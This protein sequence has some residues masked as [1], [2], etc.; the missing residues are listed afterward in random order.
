MLERAMRQSKGHR[1]LKQCAK[2]VEI[3]I[4]VQPG[5]KSSELVGEYGGALKIKLRAQPVD[6]KANAALVEFMSSCLGIPKSR[7]HILSGVTVRRKKILVEGLSLDVVRA[8]LA[9]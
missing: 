2:G 4:H 6:G 5:A 3:A 1:V 8:K 9:P 7:I